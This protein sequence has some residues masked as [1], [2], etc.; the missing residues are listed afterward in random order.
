MCKEPS[1]VLC[2]E[3]Q[4]SYL[5]SPCFFFIKCLLGVITSLI[6]KVSSWV[7]SPHA[8]FLGHSHELKTGRRERMTGC[9]FTSLNLPPHLL[10]S[11]YLSWLLADSSL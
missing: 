5:S 6:R 2:K 7:N 11:F 10:L 9:E 8:C 1:P 4:V 3:Q